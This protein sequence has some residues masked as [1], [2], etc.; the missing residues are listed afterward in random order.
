M[1]VLAHRFNSIHYC[2]AYQPLLINIVF[3]LKGHRVRH[4]MG[5]KCKTQR[6][7][8]KDKSTEKYKPDD[9]AE[10]QHYTEKQ[11]TTKIYFH[12]EDLK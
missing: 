5:P 6:G 12:H 7:K 2:Y 9:W 8:S 1:Y 3:C 10:A 4:K 11:Q